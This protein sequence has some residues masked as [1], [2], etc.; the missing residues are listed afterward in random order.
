MVIN[1]L[2]LIIVGF[3][4]WLM[5]GCQLLKPVNVEKH[6]YLLQQ[7]PVKLP[8]Y[9]RTAR[10]L[11]VQPPET[12]PVFDRNDMAYMANSYK[13]AYYAKN[14]WAETPSQMLLPLLARTLQAT[15]YF[16]AVMSSV[17]PSHYDFSLSSQILQFQFNF[18]QHT[19]SFQ[20]LLRVELHNAVMNKVIATQD[21]YTNVDM[22]ATNPQQGVRAANRATKMM[23]RKVALFVVKMIKR[24][25][26]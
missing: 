10:V 13:I 15:H 14:E 16:N 22:Q 26:G 17:N 5:T 3:A 21:F 12:K 4:C 25:H 20:F 2:R 9:T 6:S 7:T 18:S 1:T 23:L 24:Q 19:P 11:L 8:T